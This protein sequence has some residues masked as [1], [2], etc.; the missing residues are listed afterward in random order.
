[1]KWTY[2]VVSLLILPP[3]ESHSDNKKEYC[4]KDKCSS[5]EVIETSQIES[6]TVTI[7]TMSRTIEKVIESREQDEGMGARVRRS[8]G[9]AELRNLDPFL[10]LDEFKVKKPAGFPDHPHRG[11]ETVTYMLEGSFRH[12]DFCGHKGVINP[13]DLQWMTAGRGILH[14]EMPEGDEI[15]HGLQL[16]VNLSKQNKMVEPAYQELLDKDIPKTKQNGVSVKVIAGESLGIKSPVKTRTP[17]MY[18]DFK[19]DKG[20]ALKQAVPEGWNGFVYVLSGSALFG[21]SDNAKQGPPHHTLLLGPGNMLD[22]INNGDDICHFVLIAGKP[23]NEP[24]VQHGPFVMNEQKEIQEA[25]NDYRS[26]RNGFEKARNWQS[27]AGR[28]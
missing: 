13:G 27:S 21:P 23:L 20:A 5:I 9:N 10:L 2:L 24:I 19:L 14:C 26:A 8:I 7:E 25:I 22:V 18:L 6:Y 4:T 3:V 11:F 12:E 1:M 28:G 15:G 16:W 17:T